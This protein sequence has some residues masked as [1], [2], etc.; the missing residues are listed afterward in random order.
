M[1]LYY[2]LAD[3]VV[4][5]EVIIQDSSVTYSASASAFASANT[6][7]EDA[8]K[9]ATIDSNTA[10]TIAARKTVDDILKKYT[11]VLADVNITE[12]INNSLK[13]SIHPIIPIFLKNIATTL[14]GT[15]YTLNKNTT[16]AQNEYLLIPSGNQFT[17]PKK[18]Q[19]INNGIIQIGDNSN[20]KP[21]K[22]NK[23]GTTAC[24]TIVNYEN[25]TSN[26]YITF[27]MSCTKT[28]FI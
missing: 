9:V 4:N 28:T 1:A 20:V 16:I 18:L 22:S 10:A 19:F 6:S 15:S 2:C 7:F 27:F 25:I 17:I 26:Q 24:S 12:M 3:T 21:T 5:G 23:Q 14:D 11:Y 13:T 8:S